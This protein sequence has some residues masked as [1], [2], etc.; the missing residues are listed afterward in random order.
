LQFGKFDAMRIICEKLHGRWSAWI[1][2]RHE[3]VFGGRTYRGAVRRLA[4]EVPGIDLAHIRP[5]REETYPGRIVLVCTEPCPEC[6]GSGK[7]VGLLT[8]EDCGRCGGSGRIEDER[9]AF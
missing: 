1:E 3:T 4:A 2:G 6:G 7:Y 9:P 8:V 5:A